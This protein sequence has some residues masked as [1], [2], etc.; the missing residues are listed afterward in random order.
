MTGLMQREM[1]EIFYLFYAG[2]A[3]M[4]LFFLR[5]VFCLRL[6]AYQRAQ[7][8]AYLGFWVVAAFLFNRFLYQASYGTLSW[9]GILAFV[10]GMILWKRGICVILKLN[11]TVHKY[12]RENI[13]HEEKE[14]ST[15]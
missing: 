15:H 5:D 7:K 8:A 10:L 9:Y 2:L 12:N 6:Q 13:G 14:K 11:D 4:L 1:L 3:V